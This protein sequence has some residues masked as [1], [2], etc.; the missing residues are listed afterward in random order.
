MDSDVAL[1]ALVLAVLVTATA[2]LVLRP[3]RDK[4]RADDRTRELA[5][6]VG[7]DVDDGIV[8]VEHGGRTMLLKGDDQ[9]VWFE[10]PWNAGPALAPEAID[11]ATRAETILHTEPPV[12]DRF[13]AE[14][15]VTPP[16]AAV[17]EAVQLAL[18]LLPPCDVHLDRTTLRVRVRGLIPT[19]A[20]SWVS[21]LLAMVVM[22]ETATE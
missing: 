15:R 16:E 9:G 22:L 8:R 3:R 13:A 2:A 10:V 17:P 21:R 12:G 1:G 5:R 7:G 18:V 14:F 6:A 11:G 20:P 4:A 19:Q